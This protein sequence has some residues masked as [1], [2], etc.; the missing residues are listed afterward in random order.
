MKIPRHCIKELIFSGIMNTSVKGQNAKPEN[1]LSTYWGELTGTDFIKAVGESEGTC[2]LPI[3]VFENRKQIALSAALG[4]YRV[5]VCTTFCSVLVL[6]SIQPFFFVIL[7]T[8]QY[9]EH[10]NNTP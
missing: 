1:D 9:S 2:L 5:F 10:G 4:N 3:G 6:R 8:E 7:H